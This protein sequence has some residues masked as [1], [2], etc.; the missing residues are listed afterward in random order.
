M[1]STARRSPLLPL[2]ILSILLACGFTLDDGVVTWYW[3]RAPWV[4]PALVAVGVGLGT[5][6]FLRRTRHRGR[7]ST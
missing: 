4:A 7:H 6:F 3:E 2:A 1:A 5:A